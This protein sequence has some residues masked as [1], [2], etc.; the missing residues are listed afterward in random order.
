MVFPNF[1]TSKNN[2]FSFAL[3]RLHSETQSDKPYEPNP[4]A[5][6]GIS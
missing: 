3:Y 1:G 6:A 5:F 4:K 2:L